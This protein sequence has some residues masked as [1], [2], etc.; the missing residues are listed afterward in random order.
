MR[1]IINLITKAF[2]FNNKSENFKTDIAIAKNIINLKIAM[3]IYK[4]QSIIKK[5][6]NLL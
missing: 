5:L 4:K 3:K 1:H 2:I 6:Q